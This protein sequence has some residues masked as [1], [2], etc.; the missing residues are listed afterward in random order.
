MKTYDEIKD[1]IVN[2]LGL[3]DLAAYKA[4]CDR[5]ARWEN[6]V[7]PTEEDVALLSPDGIDNNAF[8]RLAE[9]LFKTDPVSNCMGTD[10]VSV[11]EANRRN[12]V[13]Y[14]LDGF[15]GV[16]EATKIWNW[17]E[18][19][20]LLEIGP[21]YGAFKQWLRRTSPNWDYYAA[22]SYP[23]I[24]GV[25]ATELNGRL[26]AVTK[27]RAYNVAIA[28][29]VFQHL[30]VAQRCNY[31][32]DIAY[33]LS[34]GGIFVVSQMVDCLPSSDPRRDSKGRQWCRHY[35]QFT[36]IQCHP[37]IV[38]DLQGYFR[39]IQSTVRDNNWATFVCQKLVRAEVESPAIT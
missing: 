5:H 38:R 19:P 17:W 39:I 31:Y 10:P 4:Y 27:D 24:E 11:E 14:H 35:G 26:S 29:N 13:M 3:T 2:R 32:R 23:R 12:M 18:N 9:E 7:I 36:E 8:W 15:I 34:Q 22:D 30:S 1:I 20:K 33:S 16:I 25:D 6:P 37:A 28:S 21:G